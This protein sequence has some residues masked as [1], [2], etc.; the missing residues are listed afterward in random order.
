MVLVLAAGS[1]AP[2]GGYFAARGLD[3]ADCF[4]LSVGLGIGLAADVHVTDYMAP[5]LGIASYT[6]NLGWDDRRVNGVWLES[7]VINTPR[8]AYEWAYEDSLAA[9]SEDSSQRL[10]TGLALASLTLPNERWIR[11]GSRVTVEY[12]SLFNFGGLGERM[13][14]RSLAGV[15]LGHGEQADDPGRSFWQKC[16][17]EAGATAGVVHARVGWNP[18]ETIDFLLGWIGLD[19]AGDSGTQ[20]VA[21]IR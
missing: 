7:D 13:A 2:V 19:P 20:P 6:A 15:L 12:F 16:F 8:L 18:L 21:P 14:A 5:G 3:L 17:L 11:K 1:C 10:L 9:D 4:K